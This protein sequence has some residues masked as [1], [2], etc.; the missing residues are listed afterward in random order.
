M[1]H[2]ILKVTPVGRLLLK[3]R[4]RKTI[5]VRSFVKHI[6]RAEMTIIGGEKPLQFPNVK[7]PLGEI[8]SS[9]AGELT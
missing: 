6:I 4:G 2:S 7:R 9:A 5:I 3:A 1:V 8:F